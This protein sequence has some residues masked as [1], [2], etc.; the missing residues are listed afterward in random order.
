MKT[1]RNSIPALLSSLGIAI[2]SSQASA[3]VVSINLTEF[4]N[5]IQQI[6]S[7]E[8]FGIAAE[9]SVVG[10][11]VNLNQTLT[12][13]NVA[14]S[15]GSPTTVDVS[16]TAPNGWASFN[17]AYDD[18]PLKAGIDDY[19]GTGSPTTIVLADLNATFASGYKI[20]VYLTGFNGN[21]GASISDG[22]TTYFF[23]TIGSPSAP[24]T[25][26]RTTD[27]T[28]NGAGT[29]PEAQYAVFGSDVAPL[30]ANSITLTL[31]TLYGGGSGLGGVQIVSAIPEP[32]SLLL[33]GVGV[34][35]L[36]LRR[37]KS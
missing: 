36:A 35:P 21:T 24:V 37:R 18:T 31:D 32:G 20:I 29:A 14:D 26:V 13:T 15:G 7:D 9:G 11:W 34:L 25:L 33:L 4:A 10:G 1:S 12:A 6:N 3:T 27:T 19:T 23:Q 22:T 28:D 8:T 16:G 5:D 17:A 30:T 2:A